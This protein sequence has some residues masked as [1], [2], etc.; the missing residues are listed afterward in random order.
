MSFEDEA[1]AIEQRFETEWGATT[2]IKW[3]NTDYTPDPDVTFTEL[4]IHHGQGVRLDIGSSQRYRYPG[5]ISINIRGPLTK[6]TRALKTLADTAQA[7][8]QGVTFSGII[9]YTSS[10]TRI[11]EV[12]GRFVYNVSTPFT[13]DESF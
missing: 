12:D 8:F 4:E 6:G 1:K 11:G 13:R 7:V 3:E 10:I 2:P 5:I 9:C